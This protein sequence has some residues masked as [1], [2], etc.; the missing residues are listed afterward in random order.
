VKDFNTPLSPIDKSYRQKL[1]GE[2]MKRTDIINQ[3]DLIDIYRI[4]HP[5]QKNISSSQ[6]LVEPSE[7][8]TI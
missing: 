2:I 5:N 6:H 1:N 7:K 3:T 8:L 4:F